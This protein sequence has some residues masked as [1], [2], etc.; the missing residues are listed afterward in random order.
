[1]STFII[2]TC[3]FINYHNDF[4][5][6]E[7]KLS[8]ETREIIDECYSN[9]TYENLLII[10]SIVFIELRNKFLLSEERLKEFYFKVFKLTDSADKINIR[11]IDNE[12]MLKFLTMDT[13]G[14]N[15]ER[16][17]KIVLATALTMNSTIIT[18]DSKIKEFVERSN[19]IAMIH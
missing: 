4:F 17:D 8:K 3:A 14:I 6:E 19:T 12:V 7:N 15:F 16:I 10:P 5:K 13:V 18:Y 9:Y 2:D 1:M 11:E